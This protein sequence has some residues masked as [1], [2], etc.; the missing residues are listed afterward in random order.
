MEEESSRA[1]PQPLPESPLAPPPSTTHPPTHTHTHTPLVQLGAGEL[2]LSLGHRA[3][4]PQQRGAQGGRIWAGMGVSAP[5]AQMCAVCAWGAGGR[6]GN[7]STASQHPP[8]HTADSPAPCPRL[9]PRSAGG[10]VGVGLH[11]PPP[12]LLTHTH[13]THSRAAR[14]TW[15]AWGCTSPGASSSSPSTGATW[16]QPFAACAPTRSGPRWGCTGARA[17]RVVVCGC[18]WVGGWVGPSQPPN[19]RTHD[20]QPRAVPR[21]PPLC[22]VCSLG[23]SVEV[24]FGTE[25]FRCGRGGVGGGAQPRICTRTH[26]RTHA[27]PQV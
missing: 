6:G 19:P 15:W 25:P 1:P 9:A 17:Q 8:S 11:P 22:C 14:A 3:Q 2:R 13:T 24:N 10:V 18:G 7:R 23:A 5:R 20:H 12:T 16:V 4:A 21:R 26:A 27:R